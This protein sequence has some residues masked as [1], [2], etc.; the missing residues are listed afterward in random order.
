MTATDNDAGAG[1]QVACVRQFAA[2]ESAMPQHDQ[3]PRVVLPDN[4]SVSFDPSSPDGMTWRQKIGILVEGLAGE[5][6]VE[7]PL[8]HRFAPGVYLREIF[9]PAG[10]IVIG[11]IHKTRHFNVVLKGRCHLVSEDGSVVELV[12]PC[13]FVSD[14]GVQ[15]V[16]YIDEDT[17][18]QTVHPTSETDLDKLDAELIEPADYPR[19]PPPPQ[20]IEV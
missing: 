3:V 4:R 5:P 1:A 9:M 18:W 15:K 6:Q 11:K 16:L 17:V 14:A 2:D 13:T 8:V 10:S 20:R 19:L 7:C 12:A